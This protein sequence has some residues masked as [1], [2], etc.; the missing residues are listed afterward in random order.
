[1]KS[2]RFL[3]VE[4]HQF[5]RLMLERALRVLGADSIL[6]ATNGAEAM[7]VLG[8]APVDIVITDLMM[9]D[10]DGIELIPMLRKN[11]AGVAVILSSSDASSLL[12]AAEIARAHGLALLG[13]VDK[14]ITPDK[15]RPL[16]D[17]YL[18]GRTGAGPVSAP[19]PP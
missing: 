7:R 5:Q 14:P 11:A 19:P 15:L 4:D 8:A 3:I 6:G 2:L 9:P 17:R 1:L 18:A 16:L 13:A 10:V 12:V